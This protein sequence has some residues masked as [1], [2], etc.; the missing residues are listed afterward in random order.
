MGREPD[1]SNCVEFDQPSAFIDEPRHVAPPRLPLWCIHN[2]KKM[3][4]C[5]PF[6]QV[7][8]E[9]FHRRRLYAAKIA[10][11]KRRE[12][13]PPPPPG[14]EPPK[15]KRVSVRREFPPPSPCVPDYLDDPLL[16]RL[17]WL[18]RIVTRR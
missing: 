9:E 11:Q 15:P 17:L 1:P 13:V 3:V 18:R 14:V 8:D 7:S 10:A 4:L 12:C 2:G 5:E 6:P 16:R